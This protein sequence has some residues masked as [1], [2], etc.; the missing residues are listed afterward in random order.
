MW[1]HNSISEKTYYHKIK[2]NFRKKIV[3]RPDISELMSL[4]KSLDLEIDNKSAGSFLN[5]MDSSLASYDEVE[6]LP[7]YLPEL[8]YTRDK[9]HEVSKI[10]NPYNAWFWRTDIKGAQSGILKDKRIVFKDNIMVGQVPMM[11]GAS[12]LK[13]YVPERDASVVT[14]VLDCGGTVVGKAHC[15][16]FCTS[17]GS[18]TC[19]EGPIH[20]PLK[21][22]YS[23]GGSS[24][25]CGALVAANEVDMA[26]GTDHGGSCRIPAS[27]CGLVGLKPTYGLVACSGIMPIE[28]TIDYV[29]PITRN[30]RDNALLL[31]AIAGSDGIDPAQVNIPE[32][33]D[34]SEEIGLGSSNLK[35]AVLKEGFGYP[36][37]LTEVDQ[38]VLKA[39]DTFRELGATVS[40]ISIPLHR[41][42]AAIWTPIYLEGLICSSMLD[43]G[44]GKNSEGLFLSSLVDFHSRWRD[45][46]S[47]FGPQTKLLLLLGEYVR[48][49]YGG[50]FYGKS[51]NL[52][53]QLRFEYEKAF[54]DYDIIMMPTLPM[55]STKLPEKNASDEEIVSKALEMAVNTPAADLTGH[56]SLSLKCGDVDGLPV[57]LMLTGRFFEERKIYRAAYDFE[58]S[59][60]K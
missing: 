31:T 22:G 34:Y 28:T 35:I 3:K 53:R 20:N 36:A 4:A 60:N 45:K 37:S 46:T 25:G 2:N 55:V 54:A 15:E 26:V 19:A 18:H 39:A 16:Y 17:G 52:R 29:G 42:S 8:K 5:L 49:N 30:V 14:K 10:D 43:G 50:K 56:P 32:G 44:Y 57:G 23:A 6:A 9:G 48:R 11:N 33:I 1:Y 47:L 21:R 7:D 38:S 58:N 40:E 41:V 13:G 51:Q 12:T 24:S 27:F 59:V